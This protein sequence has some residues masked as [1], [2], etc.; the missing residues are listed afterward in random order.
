MNKQKLASIT[1]FNRKMYLFPVLSFMDSLAQQNKEMDITRYHQLKLVAGE[2]IKQRIEKAYPGTSGEIQIEFSFVND[3]FE[4]SVKDKGVPGWTDFTY[5]RDNI[6][7]NQKD[8]S[9]YITALFVDDIGLEKLGNDGQRVYIRKKMLNLPKFVQP[10][11]YME[12]EALDTDISIRPVTTEEDVI[13]AIRCIYSEYG[14]SY[15]YERLYY[16]DSF[17]KLLKSGEIMSFLAVNRH[18]QTAGHF[19]LAF[20]DFYRN[21]PEISTVVVTKKFRGCGLFAKFMDYCEQL[22]KDRGL[23]AIMGQPVTFHPMSQKAFLR[24]GYMATSLLMSYLG[25]DIESEY[26]EGDERLGLCVA[27]KMFDKNAYSKVYVPDE[28]TGFAEKM[29]QRLGMKY[30][31]CRNGEV[32][33]GTE[34]STEA[35]SSLK[36]SKIIVRKAGDDFEETLS[37]AVKAAIKHKSEM[38]ELV[39]SMNAPSC[40][41]AY[42]IAKKCEF[43]FSGIIP[44]A[45]NGDFIIM[46]ILLGDEMK[47][48]K[49]VTVGEFE[50]LKNNVIQ[51]IGS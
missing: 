25:T 19:I 22:A 18:G 10:E 39:I 43:N 42:H 33:D 11:P 46:Q 49:L 48:D 12:T 34:L 28:I 24:A 8:R 50:E 4:I 44:G 27:V 15:S 14:Y 2:V 20:S 3:Y 6:L 41:Y 23:R 45:E 26:N 29:Y 37:M 5:N 35:V 32:A 40:A 1:I 7:E 13:E 31:I 30:D 17:M 51:I 21:M 38:I 9:N 47:Y 36:M 16:V